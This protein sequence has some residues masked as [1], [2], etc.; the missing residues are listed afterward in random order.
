MQNGN[1]THETHSILPGT[2]GT[3]SGQTNLCVS[4]IH[5]RQIK[6]LYD[7]LPSALRLIPCLRLRGTTQ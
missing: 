6:A 7:T 2:E 5:L 4:M 1:C 3:D